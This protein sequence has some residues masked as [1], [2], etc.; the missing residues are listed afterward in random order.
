MKNTRLTLFALFALLAVAG[1]G[2][3]GEPGNTSTSS[4]SNELLSYVPADTPYVVAN[5]EPVPEDVLD[6]FLARLQPV[7]DTMQSQLTDARGALEAQQD[8]PGARFAHALLMEFDGKLS[9]PGLESMGLICVQNGCFT[10]W[11]RFL[12]S[13]LG[14][15]IPRHCAIR[16][17]A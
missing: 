8:D 11:V 3:N 9:R 5:L 12:L 13:A 4:S 14:F 16:S 7:L 6:T 17:F 10:E 2:N 1:C 15:Q